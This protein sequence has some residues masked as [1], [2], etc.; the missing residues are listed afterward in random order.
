VVESGFGHL[1][2]YARP[3][4]GTPILGFIRVAHAVALKAFATAAGRRKAAVA[5]ARTEARAT[6][7][8][9]AGAV[10]EARVFRTPSEGAL[11]VHQGYPAQV[12]DRGRGHKPS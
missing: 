1:G 4:H 3:L 2:L 7:F 10:D 11:D 5:S 8:T 12:R 9:S 6:G